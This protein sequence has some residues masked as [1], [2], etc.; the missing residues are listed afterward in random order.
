MRARRRCCALF[1]L[2]EEPSGAGA[3]EGEERGPA[4]DVDIGH[5]GGLLLHEAVEHAEG[6]AA[7]LRG[8]DVAREI[9]A[10]DEG[11]LLKDGVGGR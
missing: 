2:F 4:E 10:Q 11:S 5:E 3:E 6:A 7:A 8:A 1:R 9:V